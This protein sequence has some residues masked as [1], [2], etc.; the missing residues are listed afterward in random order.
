MNELLERLHQLTGW[1]IQNEFEEEQPEFEGS[2]H[3]EA[4]SCIRD[5]REGRPRCSTCEEQFPFEELD[6]DWGECPKCIK[7]RPRCP[8]C[9]MR[10]E[11]DSSNDKWLCP[12]CGDSQKEGG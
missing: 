12:A 9:A 8:D 3:C 4:G 2:F 7:E 5:I 6:D 11:H 10:L 1:T